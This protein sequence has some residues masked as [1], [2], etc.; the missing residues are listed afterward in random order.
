MKSGNIETDWLAFWDEAS[1]CP[2]LERSGDGDRREHLRFGRRAGYLKRG[3][4][5]VCAVSDTPKLLSGKSFMSMHV[6]K[7]IIAHLVA[8]VAKLYGE[9][10]ES[11][12]RVEVLSHGQ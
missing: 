4:L 5:L 9:L 6:M 12:A 3:S 10:S 11:A 1:A 2:M 7:M 8:E